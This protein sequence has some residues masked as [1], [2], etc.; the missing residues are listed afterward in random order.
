MEIR[1][2][3]NVRYEQEP[4][5]GVAVMFEDDR[6]SYEVFED[7][8]SN[9]ELAAVVVEY[10]EKVDGYYP[11]L[12]ES[13]NVM[14]D[15]AG[16]ELNAEQEQ[17]V[18]LALAGGSVT[19]EVLTPFGT[20][21]T[22]VWSIQTYASSGQTQAGERCFTLTAITEERE[23]ILRDPV[24]DG[25]S[26]I[27]EM[28]ALSDDGGG[29]I[30]ITFPI[31][32]PVLADE[33]PPVFDTVIEDGQ[34]QEI[35]PMAKTQFIPTP[36]MNAKE[37]PVDDEVQ[38]APVA[39]EQ[40]KLDPLPRTQVAADILPPEPENASFDENENETPAS[41]YELPTV[42]DGEIIE[43]E[44]EEELIVIERLEQYSLVD[45]ATLVIEPEVEVTLSPNI[46]DI[47]KS[48]VAPIMLTNVEYDLVANE[49][50][51]LSQEVEAEQSQVIDRDIQQL[52]TIMNE[53]RVV[54]QHF[55]QF[56]I[57][58]PAIKSV[59]TSSEALPSIKQTIIV[60]QTVRYELPVIETEHATV[61]ANIRHE[62]S[63][64]ASGEVEHS[65][66]RTVIDKH[67]AHQSDTE[68][69]H[70]NEV[71]AWE[72]SGFEPTYNFFSASGL[73]TPAEDDIVIPFQTTIRTRR[74]SQARRTRSRVI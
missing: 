14:G 28:L 9:P 35:E 50:V 34:V 63:N 19:V 15:N 24:E 62:I 52:Q 65:T 54:D 38:F 56:Q 72:V 49:D 74:P 5:A 44:P 39:I 6:E 66:F 20:D 40:V 67:S 73:A 29:D 41:S 22:E 7:N 10:V 55:E 51:S 57:A 59:V 21:M 8:S 36:V 71:S 33:T 23:I 42:E 11:L 60:D 37:L 13:D 3:S 30:L 17:A 46:L 45:E 47:Q 31:E 1:N 48:E 4:L 43:V 2:D 61:P 18:Q 27:S 16:L 26:P 58:I 25:D 64:V 70:M 32:Q 53:E 68:T 69:E 12:A